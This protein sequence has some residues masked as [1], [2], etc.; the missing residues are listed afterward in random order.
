MQGLNTIVSQHSGLHGT[1][2][3]TSQMP[4]Q[5]ASAP[6]PESQCR[7][8]LLASSGKACYSGSRHEQCGD[9]MWGLMAAGISQRTLEAW[10]CI[11]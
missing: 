3:L 9:L 4:V 5:A 6:A 1:T 8:A 11:Q 7:E 10:L 2:R